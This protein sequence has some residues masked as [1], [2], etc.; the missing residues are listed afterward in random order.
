MSEEA[1]RRWGAALEAAFVATFASQLIPGIIHNFANPLNGIMGRGQIMKRRIDTFLASGK[2]KDPAS[3]PAYRE[4]VHRIK[5]DVESINNEAERFFNMFQDVGSRFQ[6]MQSTDDEVFS[7]GQLI[8]TEIRFADNYLDFKHQIKKSVVIDE[9]LPVLRGNPAYYALC[10]WAILRQVV[11]DTREAADKNLFVQVHFQNR[12]VVVQFRHGIAVADLAG[13]NGQ[14]YTPGEA[15]VSL[16][17]TAMAI[18]EAMGVKITMELQGGF[19]N[20]S[21]LFNI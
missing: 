16:F 4:L 5:A 10:F 7:L 1:L 21:L 17:H 18:L 11:Y 2:E 3:L 13:H 6:R 9:N 15:E 19:R 14:G 20:L 12:Q 8:A